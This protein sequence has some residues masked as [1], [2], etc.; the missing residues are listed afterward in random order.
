[1]IKSLENDH[2]K[3]IKKDEIFKVYLTGHTFGEDWT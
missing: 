3:G 2:K 1:M